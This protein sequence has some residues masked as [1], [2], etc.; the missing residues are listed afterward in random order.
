MSA[1]SS[2]KLLNS[3][4]RDPELAHLD[5]CPQMFCASMYQLNLRE[6]LRETFELC[7]KISQ[8]S[9]FS[10]FFREA[11]PFGQKI[12]SSQDLG[13][14]MGLST[15]STAVGKV[16]VGEFMGPNGK[17]DDEYFLV[18]ARETQSELEAKG[19]K[20]AYFFLLGVPYNYVFYDDTQQK[21]RASVTVY[22]LLHILCPD[23]KSDMERLAA[24]LGLQP[25]ADE[26]IRKMTEEIRQIPLLSARKFKTKCEWDEKNVSRVFF[27][28]RW[29]KATR[30]AN[31]GEPYIGMPAD[32]PPTKRLSYN[33]LHPVLHLYYPTLGI[34]KEP[35]TTREDGA[36]SV[37]S[38]SE[39]E[40]P[41]PES[42][43]LARKRG[44]FDLDAPP[45][46]RR[47]IDLP[48]TEDANSIFDANYV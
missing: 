16:N 9:V 46:K 15:Q 39:D 32:L 22:P 14:K 4:C 10:L 27:Q 35:F 19:E 24:L 17:K 30:S 8:N 44:S 20:S 2:L 48:P 37:E 7:W 28:V 47:K 5:G 25:G 31:Q 6:T 26:E 1:S 40:V 43:P 11:F 18:H 41:A 45:S 42:E 34:H 33:D 13:S 12:A 21:M 38:E 3:K 29:R 23:I 36:E